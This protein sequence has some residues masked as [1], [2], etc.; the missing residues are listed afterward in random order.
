VPAIRAKRRGKA[1][2]DAA[3]T[4]ILPKFRN[5]PAPRW[6]GMCGRFSQCRTWREIYDLYDLRGAAR[7]LQAHY[8]IAP[9]DA[10]EVVRA[11]DGV[12]ELVPI[13]RGLIRIGGKGR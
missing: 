12:T 10:V 3:P 2:I 7:N 1:P 13:R 4:A 11:A 8:N 6:G 9:T 5:Y